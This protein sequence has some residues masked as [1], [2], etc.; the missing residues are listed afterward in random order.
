MEREMERERERGRENSSESGW[1]RKLLVS[2]VTPT[3]KSEKNSRTWR[4]PLAPLAASLK[5]T[6]KLSQLTPAFGISCL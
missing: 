5:S 1:R 4:V 2:C 6:L 3:G